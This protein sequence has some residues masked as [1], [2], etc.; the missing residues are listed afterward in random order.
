[1][2]ANAH[3]RARAGLFIVEVFTEKTTLTKNKGW[4]EGGKP[5]ESRACFCVVVH[6]N[7]ENQMPVIVLRNMYMDIN[8]KR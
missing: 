6:K 3:A 2:C 5:K 8:I 7:A 4:R 1:M